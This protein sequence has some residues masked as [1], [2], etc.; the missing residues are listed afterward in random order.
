[1]SWI[2]YA[3]SPTFRH[4]RAASFLCSVMES[5]R[6][7]AAGVTDGGAHS[8]K[9]ESICRILNRVSL[10]HMLIGNMTKRITQIQARGQKRSSIL[11]MK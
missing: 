5:E 8:W 2:S 3:A 11:F 1:M 9:P 4:L 10:C 6:V 7:A